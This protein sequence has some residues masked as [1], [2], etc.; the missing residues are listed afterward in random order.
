MVFETEKLVEPVHKVDGVVDL[1]LQLFL[2]AVDVGI[3]LGE[4]DDPEQSGEDAGQLDPVDLAQ[5]RHP[6]WQ[7]PVA[8]FPAVEHQDASGA[9]HR[10]GAEVTTV[11]AGEEDVVLIMLP[12]PGHLPQN[13]AHHLGCLDLLI[14]GFPVLFPPE[15][16]QCVPDDQA[17]GV[18]EYHSWG[19]IVETEQVQFLS[20]D[21]VVVI[22]EI[23][24]AQL[25]LGDLF[26]QGDIVD[27]F[28]FRLRRC[29]PDLPGELG[30]RV[31]LAAYLEGLVPAE[32]CS[33]DFHTFFLQH[34]LHRPHHPLACLRVGQFR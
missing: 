3:V 2:H 27:L 10:L 34:G 9:V 28:C 21:P 33:G 6:E 16:D 24:L 19:N 20:Q 7:F 30:E 11:I 4:L 18:P 17:L 14:A 8:P 26:Q 32:R 23:I 22:L 31:A 12:M 5:L 1:A 25:R 13:V 15:I 29:D